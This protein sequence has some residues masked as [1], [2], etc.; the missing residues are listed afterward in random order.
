L[1]VTTLHANAVSTTA[2]E[3]SWTSVSGAQ[4]YRVFQVVNGQNVLLGTVSSSTTAVQVTGLTPGATESFQVEAF[5]SAS[6]SD[7]S[8]VSVT[9]PAPVAQSSVTAPQLIASAASPT[10]VVLSW[11]SEPQAAGYRIYWSNGYQFA[12]LGTVDSSTTSVTVTGLRSGARSFF[13]V[14][15]FNSVSSA[16]SRWVYVATP[17]YSFGSGA[18]FGQSAELQPNA[19]ASGGGATPGGAAHAA[20][21]HEAR[22]RYF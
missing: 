8:V 11:S 5:N 4:G 18:G 17:S 3:L 20:R 10:S 9:M 16:D 14:E 22:G 12:Y 7:S 2:A 1:S 19:A 21:G 13:L 6:V 15:A